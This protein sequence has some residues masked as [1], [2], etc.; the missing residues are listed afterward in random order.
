MISEFTLRPKAQN[1]RAPYLIATFLFGAAAFFILYLVME[2]YRGVV[3]LV[4]VAFITAAVFVYTRYVAPEYYYDIMVA[5]GTPLFVVRQLTG[6][7]FVTL[8]RIDLR[9]ITS[10]TRLNAAERREHKTPTGYI[11]YNY[12]PTIGPEFVYMITSVSRYERAEIVI[13]ANEDFADLL[14]RYANEARESYVDEE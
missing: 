3:G 9:T 2:V 14:S 10:V 11:K 6:K 7:R 8:S 5:N 1:T 12:T 13:E 4:S